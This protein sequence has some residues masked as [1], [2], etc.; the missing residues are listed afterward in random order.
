MEKDNKSD[1]KP[2][3][4]VINVSIRRNANFYV[5]LTKKFFNDFQ[6]VELHSIGNAM[7]IAVETAENL[8]R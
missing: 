5:F 2:D 6:E 8:E 4:N 3:S 1:A 7:P